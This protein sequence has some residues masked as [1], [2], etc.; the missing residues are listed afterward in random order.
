MVETFNVYPKE[1][2]E[3]IQLDLE[4][5]EFKDGIFTL[6]RAGH[7]IDTWQYISSE[8]VAAILPGLPPLF[9][10]AHSFEVY[11]KDR[12]DAVR[13]YGAIFKPDTQGVTFYWGELDNA[14]EIP[15]VYVALSEVILIKPFKK[16]A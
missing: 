2:A 7:A 6:Y 10:N 11:L 4:G 12:K 13:V 14:K 3:P 16:A 15:N 8:N 5:F 9:E 1:G